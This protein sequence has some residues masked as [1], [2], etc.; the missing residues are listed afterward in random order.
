MLAI[1]LTILKIIGIILLCIIGFILLLLLIIL[2][3]PVR[4]CAK[5]SYKEKKPKLHL[6]VSYLLYLFCLI[7]SY[8][9]KL[10][11]Y[12]R[13]FG[14]KIDLKKLKSKKKK[15]QSVS[16]ETSDDK[17]S[18]DSSEK[19][20]TDT[21][22]KESES[23]EDKLGF[24]KKISS[25]KE[26]LEYYIDILTKDTTKEALLVCKDRIGKALK[27]LLPYKGKIYARIGLENAGTTGKILGIYKALYDYIGDVVVFYPVF[28]SEVIDVEFN[29][30][31]RIRF[32][33][34]LY[35]FIRI[36][37]DKNCHRLIKLFINKNKKAKK[38]KESR[39]EKA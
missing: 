20:E 12:I 18:N 11:Y 30:K 34:V 9:D 8:S 35:H 14:I 37:F 7:V 38:T 27:S 39:K 31:G 19:N 1:F 21:D 25:K 24:I 33:T 17:D 32:I 16:L 3:V 15:T 6:R 23:D 5:G 13:L 4:Y 29:L 28:D 2:F 36:Y 10:D 26:K 22:D